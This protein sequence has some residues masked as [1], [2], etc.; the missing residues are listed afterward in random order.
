[1]AGYVINDTNVLHFNPFHYC[2]CLQ[3]YVILQT[4]RN[5]LMKE[6]DTMVERSAVPHVLYVLFISIRYV[7]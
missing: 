6:K 5:R 1:M 4:K 3:H 2:W 7:H